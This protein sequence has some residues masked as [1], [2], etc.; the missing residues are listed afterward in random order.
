MKNFPWNIKL[1][2]PRWWT[3]TH[4]ALDEQ[5]DY[6]RWDTPNLFV[7][8][9]FKPLYSL[10]YQRWFGFCI[11]ALVV[12]PM[13]MATTFSLQLN[14]YGELSG[15]YFQLS[16]PMLDLVRANISVSLLREGC[17]VLPEARTT[18]IDSLPAAAVLEL[19][20]PSVVRINGYRL[21]MSIVQ[22]DTP[23][24]FQLLASLDNRT[25]HQAGAP[26][27]R[28]TTRGVRFLDGPYVGDSA[29]GELVVAA[30]LRPPWPLI[31]EGLVDPILHVATLAALAALA[32]LRRPRTACLAFATGW[33][34]LGANAAV[35]AA[36]YLATGLW[37]EAA[38]PCALTAF[39]A[40]AA[41]AL[42]FA[43]A[44]LPDALAVG[45]AFVVI[46]RV[47]MDCAAWRDAAYLAADPPVFG[48]ICAAAG[49]AFATL[50]FRFIRAAQRATC[51]DRAAYE[52]FRAALPPQSAGGT[53][54]LDAACADLAAA[55]A[56]VGARAR[57][58]CRRRTTPLTVDRRGS[59]GSH[60]R[61]GGRSGGGAGSLREGHGDVDIFSADRTVPGVPDPAAPVG[62]LGQLYSQVCV[63]VQGTHAY[64]S[65]CV[66]AL[67][68]RKRECPRRRERAGAGMHA[69][70]G[71]RC[72]GRA[73]A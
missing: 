53:A 47:A 6:C 22:Q 14:D 17:S 1:F 28:H 62:S 39:Y 29:A 37:R 42:R 66:L 16:V 23:L 44:R 11:A 8:T 12:Y 63:C 57:Q 59:F 46:V 20:F 36:G 10:F 72:V 18:F 5:V 32:T 54:T 61:R 49:A 60:V 73:A 9:F 2:R 25:W 30:D 19:S 34:L 58:L 68:P 45:G 51:A 13:Y 3:S 40:I 31:L 65:A 70:S 33:A 21:T 64:L 71:G 69:G 48:A 24:V 38:P 67:A 7:I 15:K 41:A 35:C 43:H 52:A 50:R 56:C 26:T 55:A 27:I 4:R